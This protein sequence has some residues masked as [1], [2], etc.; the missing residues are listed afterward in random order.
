MGVGRSDFRRCPGGSWRTRAAFRRPVP[1]RLEQRDATLENL[2][3]PDLQGNTRLNLKGVIR[4]VQRD[5]SV[6]IN[7]WM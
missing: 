6:A 2:Q 3:L 4:G 1:L 7:G 5:G